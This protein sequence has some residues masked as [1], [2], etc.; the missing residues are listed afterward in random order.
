MPYRRLPN[1]DKARLRAL[2]KAF[3]LLAS[4]GFQSVPYADSTKAQLRFLFPKFQHALI[5]L[6]ADRKNQVRKN[7]EYTDFLR[8]ARMYISHYIQVMN[9]AINRGEL[10]SQI[11]EFYQLTAFGSSLPPLN[12][13]KDILE[14]GKKII[15]GDQQRILKGGS[16]IYN[17]SIALVKVHFEKFVDAFHFQKTLQANT[18][19]S[20]NIVCSLR[21][22]AD[23]LILQLWNEIENNYVHLP[24]FL[25]RESAQKYGVTYVLRK[26]EMAR[27][28]ASTLEPRLN[29]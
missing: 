7:K 10:K 21:G 14:W 11:L 27:L 12:T 4:D 19:R 15:A 23:E 26:T 16:P 29:F 25:K 20:S 17:P 6:D 5:I 2:E 9:F 24:D 8:K 28:N 18:D 22:Q 3:K 1:T 13:E